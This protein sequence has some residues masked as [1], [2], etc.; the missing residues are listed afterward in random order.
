VAVD[1]SGYVY[2]ADTVNHLIRKIS[3]AGVVTTLA[4]TGSPGV[5]NDTGTSASFKNPFG[6]AV[7]GSGYVYVADRNNHLI[8]KISPA[9]DVTTL[10]GNAG[11]T[12]AVN[13]TGTS[14]SFFYPFG[15]AVDGSGNVYVADTDNHLIRRVLG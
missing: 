14:A 9:G 6:V 8:R 10:A 2:V 4:G 12:G 7:D 13:D 3:P 5:V 11:I 1:G 15:V